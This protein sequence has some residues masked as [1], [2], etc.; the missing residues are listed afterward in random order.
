M[1]D[2][3]A[4]QI[5]GLAL[6]KEMRASGITADEPLVGLA[7]AGV[8][9]M[10]TLAHHSEEA[11]DFVMLLKRLAGLLE[12]IAF[13]AVGSL[14]EGGAAV[15]SQAELEEV[16]QT[17]VAVFATLE[18]T[19]QGGYVHEQLSH[20]YDKALRKRLKTEWSARRELLVGAVTEAALAIASRTSAAK[21]RH[22][23]PTGEASAV[24]AAC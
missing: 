11:Y 23:D 5:E 12:F 21:A 4:T 3:K 19:S 9:V 20:R 18:Q 7:F 6:T 16:L 22:E 1:F 14:S 24:L 8:W 13:A 10:Q 15:S 2:L 17:L